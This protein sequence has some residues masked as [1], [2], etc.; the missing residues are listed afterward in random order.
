MDAA[1]VIVTAILAGFSAVFSTSCIEKYGGAL[2][3]VAAGMPTTIV[4]ASVGFA[5]IAASSTQLINIVYTVAIGV[6]LN[7][8]FLLLWRELPQSRPFVN[9]SRSGMKLLALTITTVLFWIFSAVIVLILLFLL[10]LAGASM[11]AIGLTCTGLIVL[12]S[13][14]A[15]AK[16]Q[17]A[18]ASFRTV[19]WRSYL[20]RGL[21]AG[22]AIAVAVA[23][24]IVSDLTA[25]MIA[26]FPAVLLVMMISLFW[27]HGEELP[28]GAVSSMMLGSLSTVAYAI[29]FGELMRVFAEHV[30]LSQAIAIS[31][32]IADAGAILCVSVPLAFF[33]R[34][35]QRRYES[36]QRIA[37]E[38]AEI[39]EPIDLQAP[40][41]AAPRMST[42]MLLPRDVQLKGDKQPLV[43]CDSPPGVH[44][45]NAAS[46]HAPSRN[47]LHVN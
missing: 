26:A 45:Q 2:G 4:P 20:A 25:G 40:S 23:V 28:T 21:L 17:P 13:L 15:S 41:S 47:V 9:I 33:M 35:V 6:F 34:W 8:L 11:R 19:S 38:M 32:V 10:V 31:V 43:V 16:Q 5:L 30:L 46:L 36:S 37:M 12:V 14:I 39:S 42:Q 27:T 1:I 29:A 7:A 22:G 18:P 3:G 24:S 44:E